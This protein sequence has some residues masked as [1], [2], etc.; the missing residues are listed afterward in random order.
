MKQYCIDI[1]LSNIKE[2]IKTKILSYCSCSYENIENK[3]FIL[4]D[5]CKN[6]VVEV[7]IN[8]NDELIKFLEFKNRSV[9]VFNKTNKFVIA[10]D[11]ILNLYSNNKIYDILLEKYN[12]FINNLR[13]I[14]K[15][16]K[17]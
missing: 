16:I 7:F 13:S 3:N 15:N 10:Y 9:K 14:K 17:D 5:A 11:V 1:A 6:E 2:I 12:E 8:I 4:V